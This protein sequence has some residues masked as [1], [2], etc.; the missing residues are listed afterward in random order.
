MRIF[1]KYI[2]QEPCTRCDG[3]G[4]T[5]DHVGNILE[6]D[7]KV[8]LCMC[9]LEARYLDANIGF[10]YWD[11]EPDNFDGDAHDL[12]FIVK[13]L[14]KLKHVKK[15]GTGAYIWGANGGGKSTLAML[16]LKH[17]LRYTKHTALFVPFSDLVIL[18]TRIIGGFHDKEAMAAIEYIK[19]VDF[20]VLDDIAKEF[21]NGK[22]YGRATLNSVLRYR[23]LWR[24]PTIYTA[25]TPIDKMS[26]IYGAAN[27]SIMEGRSLILTMKN[28]LDYRRER[29]IELLAELENQN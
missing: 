29:K 10:D 27:F 12:E 19:N 28:E 16:I 18:N 24:K 4:F 11:L 3:D 20:L 6:H 13:F 15:S 17:V 26:E 22:D 21:E 23:D 1:N 9:Q 2:E 14:S 25:N 7:G 5:R 8:V